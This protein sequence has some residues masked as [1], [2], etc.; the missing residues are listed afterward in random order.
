M[1]LLLVACGNSKAYNIKGEMGDSTWDGKKVSLLSISKASSMSPID[2][3]IIKDGAFELKG[4]VDSAG[5]YVLAIDNELGQPIYK[6][7]FV[8][9]NL[10]FTL[11]TGKMHITGGPVNDAYQTFSDKYDGLS[12]GVIRLNAELKADPGNHELEKAF[13]D[14]YEHFSREFRKLAV[15]TIMENLDNPLAL[16]LFQVTLAS[17]ENGDIESILSKASPEFLADPSV[18]MVSQQLALSKKVSVGQ[19]YA[20]LA[21]FDT[22]SKPI[23]LSEYV[24]K[25]S[26]VL[27][28]FWASW[29]APCMKEL[30]NVMACYEKYHKKGFEVVG[31]S[32]DK[33]AGAWKAAISKN[34]I[35]WPQ[36]SDLAGWESQAVSVYSFSGIPHT[37]LVDPKGVIIAK[38]L[39]G[40]DLAEKLSE[41]FDK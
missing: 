7:F 29:C 17:L 32:L 21:M 18:K 24:G 41:L 33:D 26:Y 4:K 3:A 30:P 14:E 10:K 27:I 34:R 2:S 36:M 25:G 5:W 31:V 11:K 19:H 35:P 40:A 37:V 12:A 28:D 6:D 8:E 38:D 16:H 9:G 15:S 13:N 23:T 22:D 1:T 39:R 20:D